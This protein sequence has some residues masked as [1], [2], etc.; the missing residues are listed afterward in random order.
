VF[1]SFLI[2]YICIPGRAIKASDREAI[3]AFLSC[4]S[5]TINTS[6]TAWPDIW[7]KCLKYSEPHKRGRERERERERERCSYLKWNK[8]SWDNSNQKMEKEK[9]RVKTR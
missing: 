8:C 1:S 9:L 7:E 2:T 5:D 3:S 6:P 4:I